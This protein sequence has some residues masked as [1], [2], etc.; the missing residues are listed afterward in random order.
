MNEILNDISELFYQELLKHQEVLDYLVQKRKI[1]LD[2]IIKFKLG[3]CPNSNFLIKNYVQNERDGYNR[4]DKLLNLIKLKLLTKPNY[5]SFFSNMIVFPIFNTSGQI[6]GWT[7][8]RF[9]FENSK[10]KIKFLHL[11]YNKDLLYNESALN[12]DYVVLVEAPICALTLEQNGFPAVAMMGASR[13]GNG[14]IEKLKKVKKIYISF[15]SERSGVG[16]NSSLKLAQKLLES[17]IDP[18]IIELP[19]FD[20]KVDINDYFSWGFS[21]ADSFRRLMQKAVK[22]SS[23]DLS[24]FK[25]EK[26]LTKNGEDNRNIVEVVSKYIKL[27]EVNGRFWGICPFHNQGRET[28]ASLCVGGKYNIFYC[29]SCTEHGGPNEFVRMIEEIDIKKGLHRS[30]LL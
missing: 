25:R 26:Y 5:M 14:I 22:A 15:D 6:G 28:K 1:E 20:D 8:R 21:P 27:K 24:K 30:P 19:M 2:T 29:F 17:G 13:I 18:F 12:F 10:S 7:S 9:N 4:V 16:K 23:L 11:F 3:Y